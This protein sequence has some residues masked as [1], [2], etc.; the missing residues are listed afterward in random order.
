MGIEVLY[1]AKA[2]AAQRERIGQLPDSILTYVEGVLAEAGLA[3]V[4]I[5]YHHVAKRR[6]IH[7]WPDL[8]VILVRDGVQNQAFPWCE[9]NS[10][11]PV[12]PAD[13]MPIYSEAGTLMLDYFQWF[14]VSARFRDVLPSPVAGFRWQG[15][16][17]IVLNAK[18]FHA[19]EV[20]DR[21]HIL[22]GPS[23]AVIGR[24]G[25]DPNQST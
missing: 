16:H 19:V 8:A 4:A 5:R 6:S 11:T 13:L 7:D 17:A 15:H 14:Q 3:W 23:I 2:V 9:A 18:H 20:D 21:H 24:V 25:A 22:K 10:E 12:L 1:V